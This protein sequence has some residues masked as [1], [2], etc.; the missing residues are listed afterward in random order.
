MICPQCHKELYDG[1]VCCPECGIS[2]ADMNRSDS[3]AGGEKHKKITAIVPWILLAMVFVFVL[4]CVI[5]HL[6]VISQLAE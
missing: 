3:S 1:A 4:I 6:D 2:A 5:M